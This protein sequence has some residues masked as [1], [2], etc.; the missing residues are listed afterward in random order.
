MR[1]ARLVLLLVAISMWPARADAGWLAWL[2]E[3]SG[4]GPFGGY[5]FGAPVVCLKNGEPAN[6]WGLGSAEARQRIVVRF[7]KFRSLDDKLRFK[8]LPASDPHN[9]DPVR[10]L[11]ISA[12]FTVRTANRVVEAGVGAGLMRFSGEDFSSFYRFTVTPV[13]MSVRP[14]LL[15]DTDSATLKRVLGV[16][17]AE[18]DT[19]WVAKGFKGTDFGNPRTTFKTGPEFL[20]RVGIVIDVGDFFDW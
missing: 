5:V 14:L 20:T 10:V 11:P 8:D 2:E 7:G 17:R 9:T 1:H 18:L 6:C 3:L 16:L 13:N 19:T 12:L 15:I 4:P